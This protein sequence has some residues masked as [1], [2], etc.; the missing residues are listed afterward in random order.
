VSEPLLLIL[1]EASVRA[2]LLAA[3]VAGLLRLLRVPPGAPRHTAW[4]IV[5]IAMVLMPVLQRFS[6]AL[7]AVSPTVPD[8]AELFTP[9]SLDPPPSPPATAV[10][11]STE[12][13]PAAIVGASSP[14][15]APR[16]EPSPIRWPVVA[17]SLYATI[18]VALLF[19]LLL[20]LYGVRRI[21]GRARPVG[22]GSYE[23][24]DLVT[25]VTVGALRSRVVLPVTWREWPEETRR[26]VLCHERAHARRRDPFVAL[27]ARLNRCIFWFHPL[28]WW[29][30][31]TLADCAEDACDEAAL[32]AVAEPHQYA[33]VLL[34]M[35]DASRRSGGRLAWTGAH[36]GGGRLNR[37]IDRIL[38]GHPRSIGRARTRIAGIGCAISVVMA[39]AC[40]SERTVT[41]LAPPEMTPEA[42]QRY[43]ASRREWQ[44][45]MAAWNSVRAM[46]WEQIA[47]LEA[48]WRR[49]PDDLETLEKLLFFYTPDISGKPSPDDAKKI[50]G[51]RPL[52]LWFIEHHPDFEFHRELHARIFGHTDWLMDPVGYEAAKKLWLAHAARPDVSA[53]TLKNAASFLNV[54]DKPLAERLL[55]QGQEKYPDAEWSGRLATL[56]ATAILGS[57]RFTLGNVVNSTSAAEARGVFATQ[58]RATLD[59]TD[60][61]D[62]LGAAGRYLAIAGLRKNDLDLRALGRAYLERAARLDPQS[63]SIRNALVFDEVMD[64]YERDRQLLAGVSE[65]S[66]PGFI[67]KLPESD[68]LPQLVR[69][70]QFEFSRARQFNWQAIQPQSP[71][72]ARPEQ[73][74][75]NRQRAREA[76]RRSKQYAHDALELAKR[77]PGHPDYANALFAATVALGANVY[78][79][80]DRQAAVRY[81]LA[82]AD[83]PPSADG[84]P[85]WYILGFLEQTLIYRLLQDGERDTVVEYFERSGENRPAD[86]ERLLAAAEALRNGK[87]PRDYERR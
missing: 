12:A 38:R 65:E 6:P 61:P 68:R 14:V 31:R 1:L 25:P 35:A 87:V 36:V 51:R 75:E 22:D 79:E 15:T 44:R 81:M 55:L 62:L 29:L 66:L 33:E 49:N 5:V 18:A 4:L 78:V 45:R 16:T 11:N 13:T 28:S 80:G 58:A 73:V 60:D 53:E 3:L 10:P 37:R 32:R 48:G 50:A 72:D 46:T 86:R 82:A 69:H 17:A 67:A 47:E 52:I 27:L 41:P 7:P 59:A 63:E 39:V 77:L 54:E 76:W 43:E 84:R 83:T 40:Q 85:R 74:E 71:A 20:A 21:M 2:I 34:A 64:Q 24:A 8:V 26:A 42:A 30:E 70:A 9:T 57:N 56:Y 23:S 19:R